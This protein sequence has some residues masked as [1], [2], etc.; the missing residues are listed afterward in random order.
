MS[1][2]PH[3]DAY[4]T[5]KEVIMYFKQIAVPGMG[6]FSYIIGCPG[7]GRCVVV[8][9]KRDVQDYL[10]ISR[11]EGMKITRIIETHVHADHV[12]GNQELKS[13]TGAPIFYHEKAPVT[14]A[15]ETL[16]EG[17]IIEFGN[18]RLEVLYTPGH[19]PNSLSLLVTDKSR[20]D[21]PWMVLTGDAMF[22]GDV[23]RPDLVGEDV[24]EEQVANL[25]DTLYNK[26]GSLPEYIEIYPAHGQG[27]LCGKGMSFK[28]S[29]TLGFEKRA[30]PI[31]S[32]KFEQFREIMTGEFPARPRSFTHI[33]QTNIHGAPLLERCPLDRAL[34]PDR[35]QEHMDR[36]AVV[37]DARDAAA[38]GG[39]HIPGSINI[40]IEKQTA[41]WIGMVIDPGADILL[42]VNDRESYDEMCTQ[43]HRI[44][45]D[46]IYGYLAGGMNAWLLKGLPI[47]KLSPISVYELKEKLS[48]GD[49]EHIV[50][51]RTP[52]ERSG[53]FVAESEHV[54]MTDILNNGL[55]K[56]RDREIIVICGSGYRAN[57]VASFLKQEGFSHIH[58]LAGGIMAWLGAGFSLHS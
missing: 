44:G 6:C 10:D 52:A 57:I 47:E 25:Y 49:F 17:D 15:H 4:Q 50:D 58:S 26:F 3:M 42:V 34:N 30:N 36:G 55:D 41:N 43:L 40:G 51:V 16:A 28:G 54:P 5:I 39:F 9:P 11:N 27:S 2:R 38:F 19:T 8:D 46:N 24:L 21:S 33:I 23:G 22:V 48:G 53:G 20:M 12:S 14:F 7:A 45:Y 32:M 13:M 37:I 18:V 1:R 35:F 31:L 56:P 29:S